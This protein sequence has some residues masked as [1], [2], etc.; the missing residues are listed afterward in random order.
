MKIEHLEEIRKYS[1]D[2][3]N[4]NN[5]EAKRQ[6]L[7]TLLSRLFISTSA[8][9]IVDEFTL[10]AEKNILNIKRRGKCSE[11]GRA[12]T[13]YHKVIIE[14]EKNLKITGKKAVEQLKDYLFGNW[15]SG[16]GYNFTLIASDCMEW[17]IYAP[18]IET[19]ERLE[20]GTVSLAEDLSLEERERIIVTRDS[21]ES[22]YYFLDTYLF[23]S[24]RQTATLDSIKR[25]FGQHSEVFLSCYQIFF[26]YF[27]KVKSD[28]EIKVCYE[29]WKRLLSIAYGQFDATERI[30]IIHTYLSVFA[31]MLAF[32]V[33]T[34]DDH[35]DE[36]ELRGI[37][38]GSIFEKLNIKNFTDSDFFHWVASDKAFPHLKNAFRLIAQQIDAHDFSNVEEDILKGVYQELI[39]RDTRHTLGEYYTPDWLCEKLV[40]SLSI[41][42][43]NRVLDPSCGSGSFIRATANKFKKLYPDITA[44]Q[45]SH[46]VCGIDIHPLSVLISKTTLLLAIGDKLKNAKSPINLNIYLADTLLTPP[47]SVSF[48]MFGDEFSL[49][50]DDKA[51]T[52]NTN[53]FHNVGLFD[54][55]VTLSEELAEITKNNTELNQSGFAKALRNRLKLKIDDYQINSFH[56]IYLGLRR[57]KLENRDSIWKF[58]ILNLYKPIFFNKSFDFVVG[59]PPWFTYSSIGNSEY[60]KTLKQ[61]AGKYKLVPNVANMPHLEIAA[62]FLAHCT[63]YFLKDNGRLSFVLPRS[64]FAADHH[65][66]IRVGKVDRVRITELWDL[67]SVS[68]LFNVPSCVIFAERTKA[69]IHKAISTSGINGKNFKAR[70]SSSNMNWSQAKGRMTIEDVKFYISKLGK[71]TAFTNTKSK[72][73]SKINYYANKFKQGATIVPRKFYFIDIT[74]KYSGDL[75]NRVLTARSAKSMEK[76][77]KE[78]WKSLPSLEGRINTENL[79]RTAISRNVLPFYLHNPELVLLPIKIEKD[80]QILLLESELLLRNGLIENVKWFDKVENYWDANKTE[81]NTNISA[82]QW[83]NFQS[84]LTSQNLKSRAI[85]L[86]SASSKDA[87]AVVVYRDE[88]DLEFIAESK[89]YVMY[90][91][92]F[93]EANFICAFLNS[94]YANEAI[95]DF[96]TRGLFGPRDVHKTILKIPFPKFNSQNMQHLKLAKLGATCAENARSIS[97]GKTISMNLSAHELGKLRLKIKNT[98]SSELK[99]IDKL[100][101][102][103]STS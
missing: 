26:D 65:N 23:K 52:I 91:D 18:T 32:E 86:Y 51:Y 22:F 5:E 50:I 46:Q 17:V 73:N 68:P 69:N 43:G 58:I 57:A 97:K 4:A 44:E 53:V 56:N 79:F 93:D 28:S 71:R 30:F 95:K 14:F 36:K 78:P 64:F 20:S 25:D 70:L 89:T 8:K 72:D 82:A 41:K 101:K 16:E 42:G 92:N 47:A 54:D 49:K 2:I 75:K 94:N 37:I 74:Q 60:Q 90:S 96:Q 40:A 11:R 7:N 19:I 48:D 77:A 29:Q 59:N 6:R 76:D 63:N 34:K 99:E 87:N 98:L 62:V 39:D 55:A 27:Q 35:I 45:L 24:E 80:K 12:D 102:K 88:L 33:I 61:F 15:K 1:V 3:A 9:S 38:Y 103:I 31:K 100:V 10:G 81:K 85:V 21:S 84:K 83:L 67:E 13:Q 66:N